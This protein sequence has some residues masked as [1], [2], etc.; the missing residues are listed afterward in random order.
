VTEHG[1][2]LVVDND[3]DVALLLRDRLRHRGFSVDA[4]ESG[5]LAL[6][7]LADHPVDVVVTDLQMPGMSGLELCAALRAQ[8]A[9]LI[10]IVLTGQ[11]GHDLVQTALA[12]G[13]VAVITKPVSTETVTAAIVR[14]LAQLHQR[15]AETP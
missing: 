8:G 12:A 4:V 14:A 15:R 9:D 13:A 6:A 5:A 2:V 7:Y 10:T 3:E 1:R 11:G